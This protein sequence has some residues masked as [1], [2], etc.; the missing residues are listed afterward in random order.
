MFNHVLLLYKLFLIC[1][2]VILQSTHN[3]HLYSNDYI[4]RECINIIREC[5]TV[6]NLIELNYNTFL[7]DFIL[8]YNYLHGFNNIKVYKSCILLNKTLS[9]LMYFT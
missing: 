5:I 7:I 4:F 8:Q 9:L 1:F 6:I 3:N 2:I